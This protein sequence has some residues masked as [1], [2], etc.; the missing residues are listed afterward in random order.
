MGGTWGGWG[1]GGGS[2]GRMGGIRGDMGGIGGRH[3]VC[4]CAP[5]M[6]ALLQQRSSRPW[7]L[8][9]LHCVGLLLGWAL[10]A[11]L[12]LLEDHGLL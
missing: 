3:K 6:P 4:M 7:L 10:L 9:L 8:L 12:A 5:Q 11:L 1:V 2:W